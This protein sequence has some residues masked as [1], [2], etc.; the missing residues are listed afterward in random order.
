MGTEITSPLNF[1]GSW[2]TYFLQFTFGYMV[3]RLVAS[4]VR[5]PRIRHRLWGSF[6]FAAVTFWLFTIYDLF[7]NVTIT[8]SSTPTQAVGSRPFVWILSTTWAGRVSRLMPWAVELYLGVLALLLVRLVSKRIKLQALMSR[9]Y[10]ASAEIKRVFRGLCRELSVRSC[11]LKLIENLRSPG[12]ACWIRP[13]VFV[14]SELARRLSPS[15]FDDILRHEITHV[16]GRDYLWDRL[17]AL[18]CGLIWFHPA[19]WLAHKHLRWERELACDE[20]VVAQHGERRLNYAESLT[21]LASWWFLEDHHT[22]SGIGF[23]S[24]PSLLGARV[25]ALLREPSPL[26]ASARIFR[27]AALALLVTCSAGLLPHLAMGLYAVP[28]LRSAHLTSG[29]APGRGGFHSV[30]SRSTSSSVQPAIGKV[31]D[32]PVESSD[33]KRVASLMAG[34]HPAIPELTGNSPTAKAAGDEDQYPE[35]YAN[36]QASWDEGGAVAGTARPTWTDVANTA[37]RVGVSVMQTPDR[38]GERSPR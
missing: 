30:R 31:T 37:I 11:R 13:C 15:Q 23:A 38:D 2:I 8:S 24:S 12:T 19:A 36:S 28:V 18:A 1:A 25:R 3:V 26:S 6:L 7:A 21:K 35:S 4:L 32:K 17:A 33:T 20:A 34:S 10:P 22:P 9:G 16:K 14:P 29:F 27:V 5:T